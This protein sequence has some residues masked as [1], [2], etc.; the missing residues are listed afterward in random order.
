MVLSGSCG[1]SSYT[2]TCH[3]LQLRLKQKIK[4]NN[5]D[6]RFNSLQLFLFQFY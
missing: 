6:I 5:V 4:K 2:K 1:I 3:Y